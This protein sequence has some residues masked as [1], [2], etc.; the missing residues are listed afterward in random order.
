M[1]EI[2]GWPGYYVTGEGLVYSDRS[3]ALNEI[4]AWDK[5]G[6][7]HV[8]LRRS[9]GGR[10]KVRPQ[11]V[12]R[13]VAL[14]YMPEGACSELV[15]HLDGNPW[16]RNLSNLAWG[17]HADN[18]ADAKRHGT[19]GTGMK[20][21]RRKL[22]D[23]QVRMIRQRMAAGEHTKVVAKDF[24]ISEYYPSYLMSKGYWPEVQA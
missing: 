5:K 17:T 16:N 24:G 8:T 18:A 20:A 6:Y 14:A 13:L 2:A 10:L 1:K 23:D 19:L 22:T 12:H 15:R 3:G 11:P 4:K 21:R 7:P 9:E